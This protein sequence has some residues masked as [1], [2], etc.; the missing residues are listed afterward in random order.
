MAVPLA[1]LLTWTTHG[2]WLHGDRRGSADH[3]GAH[4]HGRPYIPHQPNRVAFERAEMVADPVL[5]DQPRRTI[6]EQTI[7]DHLDFRKWQLLALHVRTNHIHLVAAA[8]VPPEKIMDQ[9]KAWCT[10]RLREAD[11]ASQH[12]K[13]WTRHGSTR[14]LFTQDA[15]NRAIH[16]VLHEQGADLRQ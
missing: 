15:V 12:A 2:T 5:L 10:R 11:L 14:Y 4:Q 9:C 8:P 6:V 7:C 16:Y 13:V 3:T 1:Y